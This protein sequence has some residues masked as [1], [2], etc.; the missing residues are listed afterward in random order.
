M[1]QPASSQKYNKL[2]D[3]L[4]ELV[5]QEKAAA[6]VKIAEEIRAQTTVELEKHG[7]AVSAE[8][9]ARVLDLEAQVAAAKAPVTPTPPV[10]PGGPPA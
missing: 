2:V 10:T 5:G 4:T 9:T 1:A 8:H 7:N 3:K 6:A